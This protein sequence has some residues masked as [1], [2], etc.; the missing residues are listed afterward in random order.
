LKAKSWEYLAGIIDGEG[1][2]CIYASRRKSP[3]TGNPYLHYGLGISVYQQDLRLMKWLVFHFGGQYYRHPMKKE[4]NDGYSW[5][6]STGKNGEQFIL[7][8]IPYLMLKQ[9]QAKLALEYMRLGRKKGSSEKRRLL[10]EKCSALNGV[11]PTTNTPD[12][13]TILQYDGL[14]IESELMGDHESDPEVIQ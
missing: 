4:H 7:S 9:E 6:A 3:R 12:S 14:K 5:H 8:L 2:I 13:P 10:A 1:C 11:A